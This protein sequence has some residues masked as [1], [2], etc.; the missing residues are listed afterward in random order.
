MEVPIGIPGRS[1][2]FSGQARTGGQKCLTN[3]QRQH[4]ATRFFRV[5]RSSNTQAL[6]TSGWGRVASHKGGPLRAIGTVIHCGK[7]VTTAEGRIIGADG[8]LYAHATTSCL[9]FELPK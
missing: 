3:R 8:K 2:G 6:P 9:V 4:L 7:Q 5:H 1:G